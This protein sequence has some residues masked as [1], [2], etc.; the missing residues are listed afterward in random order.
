MLEKDFTPALQQ[1]I[2]EFLAM[3]RNGRASA[4]S[5]K[6]ETDKVPTLTNLGVERLREDL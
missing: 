4:S 5:S 2:G 3:A 1:S 6:S